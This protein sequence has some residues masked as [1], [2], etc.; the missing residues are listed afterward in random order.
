MWRRDET[1]PVFVAKFLQ[2]AAQ[3]RVTSQLTTFILSHRLVD[4]REFSCP[5]LDIQVGIDRGQAELRRLREAARQ[6]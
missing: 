5:I 4:H 1:E 6:R 3:L 2:R